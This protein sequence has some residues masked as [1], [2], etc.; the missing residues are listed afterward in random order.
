MD[1]YI[2][3]F[4]GFVF[5]IERCK[6]VFFWVEFEEDGFDIY[7]YSGVEINI[8]IFKI[9][10]GSFFIGDEMLEILGE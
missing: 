10:M 6:F 4:N 9:K 8:G 1:L 7:F 2:V 3:I 5:G